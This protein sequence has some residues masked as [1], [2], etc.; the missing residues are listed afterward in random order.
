MDRALQQR[1]DGLAD[2]CTEGE[3][4]LE[5]GEEYETYVRAIRIISILQARA[6]KLRTGQSGA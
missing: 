1:L 4:T 3:I 6:R 5:E 2:K